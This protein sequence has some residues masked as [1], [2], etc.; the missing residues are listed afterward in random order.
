VREDSWVHEV[1]W[2]DWA[3]K[4]NR[5]I[6][7]RDSMYGHVRQIGLFTRLDR[8][9][10]HASGSAPRLGQHT[11][12]ILA[13]LGYERAAVDDLIARGIAVQATNVTGRVDTRVSAA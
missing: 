3:M 11:R 12:E 6:E 8:T 5:V 1:L 4:C 2:A 7:T 9:P 10:G 13:E